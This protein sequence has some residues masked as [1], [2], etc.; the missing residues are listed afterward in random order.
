MC[1]ILFFFVVFRGLM[2]CVWVYKFR[3]VMLLCK[4]LVDD[5][6][7]LSWG[8]IVNWVKLFIVLKFGWLIKIEFSWL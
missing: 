6:K 4:C 8:V 7:L 2:I 5:V 1:K 3:R